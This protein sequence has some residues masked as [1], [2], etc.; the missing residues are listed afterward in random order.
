MMERRD[1]YGMAK[2]GVATP[3]VG[4]EFD[5]LNSVQI[6]KKS[7]MNVGINLLRFF[8]VAINT[9]F[10]FLSGGLFAAAIWS[11]FSDFCRW[12]GSCLQ[13]P[14]RFVANLSFSFDR[15]FCG[16]TSSIDFRTCVQC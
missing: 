3:N 15:R 1:R 4:Q 11:D 2:V 6:S 14:Q 5:E 12:L 16:A 7:K 10:V 8:L 9:V 13:K